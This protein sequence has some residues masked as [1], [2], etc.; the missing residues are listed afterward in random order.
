MNLSTRLQHFALGISISTCSFPLEPEQMSR[1]AGMAEKG[2]APPA[3]QPEEEENCYTTGCPLTYCTLYDDYAG[4]ELDACKWKI[5]KGS[6]YLRDGYLRLAQS[7]IESALNSAGETAEKADSPCPK[8][9]TEFKVR[10][11]GTG[12][13]ELHLKLDKEIAV[14][15]HPLGDLTKRWL[16]IA[17]LS[18]G[19]SSPMTPLTMSEWN[20]L[21]VEVEAGQEGQEVEQEAGQARLYRNGELVGSVSCPTSVRAVHA[22]RIDLQTFG[23]LAMEIDYVMQWCEK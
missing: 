7:A 10:Q 23:E 12:Y 11:A 22:R 21:R 14:Y 18:N 13:A 15:A 17:C 9:T 2:P 8:L 19:E 1:D 3:N 4:S 20:T 16:S 6:P 5:R